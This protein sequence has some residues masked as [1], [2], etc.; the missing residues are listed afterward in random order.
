[1][2][3]GGALEID[4]ARA[5]RGGRHGQVFG[6]R[7]EFCYRHRSDPQITQGELVVSG[8]YPCSD[9]LVTCSGHF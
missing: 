7:A 6:S 5:R 1:M 8:S 2:S 4:G 3:A 9:F